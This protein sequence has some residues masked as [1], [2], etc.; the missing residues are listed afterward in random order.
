[1][2]LQKQRLLL[3]PAFSPKSIPGLQLYLDAQYGVMAGNAGQFTAANTEYLS[4][5]DN[6]SLSTGDIDF[7]V[8]A[9][10]Y[11]DTKTARRFIVSKWTAAQQEW[12]LEYDTGDATYRLFVFGA[13]DGSVSLKINANTFGDPPTGAWHFIV[14]WHDSVAN[15]INIQVNNGTVDSSAYSSGLVDGTA[16]FRIGGNTDAGLYM[17]GR[18]GP[19]LFTKEVLTA[20]ERTWLYN[21]GVPR[22]Y[23]ELGGGDGVDLKTNLVSYWE[24]EEDSGNRA[25]KHGTNTLTDNNTVTG[26]NGPALL[27]AVDGDPIRQWTDL[28]GK[29]NHA[30]QTTGAA[31][32]VFKVAI[33]NG[34]P[35]VRFSGTDD[36][37]ALPDGAIP[38]TTGTMVV[39]GNLAS[40]SQGGVIERYTGGLG[41]RLVMVGGTLYMSTDGTQSSAAITGS[42]FHIYAASWGG[43]VASVHQDG[44]SII[45]FTS[46]T[47]TAPAGGNTRIGNS[48]DQG[49][50]TFDVT[51]ILV[52]D[53]PLTI[54]QRSEIF[55]LF[56]RNHNIGVV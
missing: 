35:V 36:Q 53:Q 40:T 5:A 26:A 19:V 39:V 15:T 44:T 54:R 17:D 49:F 4:I 11:L 32:P 20:A 2:L 47:P 51:T 52:L 16:P 7:T 30:T 50:L 45:N 9:W 42:S 34:R 24:L 56:G 37:M 21:N 43:T 25:D 10:V 27:P 18:I 3:Q 46:V 22:K 31:K 33:V 28:S 6:A 1:M 12:Y 55:H 23:S 41:I 38:L 8:A 48:S 14:A 29:G 13:L